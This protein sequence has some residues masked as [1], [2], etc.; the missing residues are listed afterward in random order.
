MAA[1]HSSILHSFTPLY[2]TTNTFIASLLSNIWLAAPKKKTSYQKARSRRY[3]GK[4]LK[5]KT[6]VKCPACGSPKLPHTLCMECMR[7]IKYQ[8]KVTA[9]EKTAAI[10]EK[11]NKPLSWAEAT[12]STKAKDSSPVIVSADKE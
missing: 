11:I 1:P 8:W 12:R 10:W 2:L 7:A 4:Y 6:L 5:D 9:R 3:D